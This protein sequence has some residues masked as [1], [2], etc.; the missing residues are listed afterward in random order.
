METNIRSE[1]IQQTKEDTVEHQTMEVE[2]NARTLASR[3]LSLCVVNN[4][5]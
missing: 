3:V 4:T 1:N 2:N 5:T